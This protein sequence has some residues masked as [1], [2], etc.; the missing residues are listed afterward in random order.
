MR[1]VKGYLDKDNMTKGRK[2][3]ERCGKRGGIRVV[4]KMGEK[5]EHDDYNMEGF[6]MEK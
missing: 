1:F 6:G 4:T 3:E 2:G 5:K